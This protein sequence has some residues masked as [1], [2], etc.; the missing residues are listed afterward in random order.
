MIASLVTDASALD[1][2]ALAVATLTMAV[3][4]LL[5]AFWPARRALAAEPARLLRED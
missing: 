2:L 3:I 1:P 5:A 4:G